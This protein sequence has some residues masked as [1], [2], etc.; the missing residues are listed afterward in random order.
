M[1]LVLKALCLEPVG[2]Y[3]KKKTVF[4]KSFCLNQKFVVEMKQEGLKSKET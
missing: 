1:S 3:F 2:N 4:K